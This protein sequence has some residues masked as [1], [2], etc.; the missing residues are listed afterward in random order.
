MFIYLMVFH[1]VTL[2]DAFSTV[3]LGLSGRKFLHIL[4]DILHMNFV[5]SAELT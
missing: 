3:L 2:V 1:H 4:K 5:L